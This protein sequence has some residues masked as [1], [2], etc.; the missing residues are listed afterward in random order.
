MDNLPSAVFIIA[1]QH[2]EKIDGTGYPNGLKGKDLNELARMAA[3]V[4]VFSALTD[5][6]VYKEPMPVAKA[7]QIMTDEMTSHLDQKYVKM[8]RSI[9]IDAKLLV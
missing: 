7:M 9:L 2:H 6:R 3:V 8:F 4:D 1:E 5:R